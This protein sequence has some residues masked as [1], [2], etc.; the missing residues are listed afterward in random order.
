[1]VKILRAR[2]NDFVWKF[3]GGRR[4]LNKGFVPRGGEN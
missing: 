1:M 3:L 4:K 2:V